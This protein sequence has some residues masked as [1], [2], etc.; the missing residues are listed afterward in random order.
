ME[1]AEAHS[2]EQL[3]VVEW[4]EDSASMQA[5]QLAGDEAEGCQSS[6][7]GKA[8]SGLCSFL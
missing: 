7:W 6:A 1:E 5:A 2:K 3:D 4:L 8:P